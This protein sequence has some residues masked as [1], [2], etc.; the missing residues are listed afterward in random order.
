MRLRFLGYCDDAF[1]VYPHEEPHPAAIPK[2]APIF[3]INQHGLS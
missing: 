3:K 2:G 1:H